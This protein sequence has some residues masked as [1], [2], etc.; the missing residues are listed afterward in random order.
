MS[1]SP[2]SDA[3]HTAG[4]KAGED[5]PPS[6]IRD[7]VALAEYGENPQEAR[8]DRL[9]QHTLAN[10]RTSLPTFEVYEGCLGQM[11]SKVFNST[12]VPSA[13]RQWRSELAAWQQ[14][15]FASSLKTGQ[16]DFSAADFPRPSILF[17]A[18]RAGLTRD[19]DCFVLATE[20]EKAMMDE[21]NFSYLQRDGFVRYAGKNRQ[22]EGL[23]TLCLDLAFMARMIN[24]QLGAKAANPCRDAL[25]ALQTR[26]TTVRKFSWSSADLR[27]EIQQAPQFNGLMIARDA[28][29]RLLAVL[30]RDHDFTA[31]I[32]RDSR[33]GAKRGPIATRIAG[34]GLLSGPPQLIETRLSSNPAPPEVSTVDNLVL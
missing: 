15:I 18:V 21:I 1:I 14:A 8:I 24:R 13:N 30:L 28:S 12:P 19:P 17:N 11:A 9:W 33:I 31:G 29:D 20:I 2:T 10:L 22:Q 7:G 5:T 26:P 32:D 4:S 23:G 25:I 27:I 3:S 16:R 34:S 6:A